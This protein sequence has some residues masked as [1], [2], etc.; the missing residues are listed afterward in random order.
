MCSWENQS[1]TGKSSSEVII[2]NM[3]L[4]GPLSPT[5]LVL[6]ETERMPWTM[7]RSGLCLMAIEGIW[8]AK[9]FTNRINLNINPRDYM[10]SF[11]SYD[12]SSIQRK[13]NKLSL[14]NAN[15]FHCLVITN[16]YCL[17]FLFIVNKRLVDHLSRAFNR[18]LVNL[19]EFLFQRPI[20]FTQ[21]WLIYQ[22]FIG[23]IF[24][25]SWLFWA[26]IL[27]ICQL[28]YLLC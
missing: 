2:K 1:V 22:G 13:I 23:I 3:L 14:L 8:F 10:I 12:F 9:R 16:L 4:L 18:L 21:S 5:L 15:D 11:N 6:K 24:V 17:R 28:V 25:R 27:R 20:S 7:S 26:L 19:I